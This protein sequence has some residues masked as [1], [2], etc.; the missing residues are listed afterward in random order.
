MKKKRVAVSVI[1]DLVSDQRVH[2][3]CM[4]LV[5][6][7]Y[8]VELIGR[9]RRH[10]PVLATRP[11]HTRRMK[12]LFETGP[13]FY[14]FFNVR[15]FF[16]LIFK[17]FDAFYSN[18]LDTLLPNYLAS[19]IR[20]KPIVYDAHEY[21]TGVPELAGR[22]MVQRSWKVIE[23]MTVPKMKFMVTV[24]ESIAR[25]YRDEYGVSPVVVRNIP[26][27]AE[28]GEVTATTRASLG[29]P[30]DRKILILQGAGINIQRGA[31]EAVE[32]MT[33]NCDILLLI[34][35]DGDV[36]DIL[37]QRVA[38]LGIDERV[39]FIPR[40]PMQELRQYTRLA[41]G[42]LT[43]DKDTNINYRYS[44]PNKLFDY[45]RAGIPVLASNLPEIRHIIEGYGIG[46]ITESH[47]P[48]ILAEKM[49]Q[50]L[51]DTE[52]RAQWHENL[53][54]ASEELCWEKEQLNLNELIKKAYS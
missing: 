18:D 40:V 50:L 47:E 26:A 20:R 15:L 22:P 19:R 7:G 14:A 53:K 21:F 38:A 45:I 35:G 27:R 44:L 2:R 32:A 51:F 11:Y 23:R 48:V 17:R 31:E 33:F 12:L 54:R 16:I 25:L 5:S 43:L 1:N 8:E 41:D 42:G 49:R 34:V 29:L 3:T 13:M 36:V 52:A 6:M 9:V 24:N 37:K 30:S 39:R 10:S 46:L 4:V 28:E